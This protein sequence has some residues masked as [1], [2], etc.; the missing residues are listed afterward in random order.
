MS[1][2]LPFQYTVTMATTVLDCT[3]HEARNEL[4][5]MNLAIFHSS[6]PDGSCGI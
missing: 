3:W 6:G 4:V 5:L 2:Q 1:V